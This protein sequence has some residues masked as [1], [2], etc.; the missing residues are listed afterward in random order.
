MNKD[1]IRKTIDRLPAIL[2]AIKDSR[3][4]TNSNRSDRS[5]KAPPLVDEETLAIIG[6]LDDIIEHEPTDWIRKLLESFKRKKTD[7][8]RME[9]VPVSRAKYDLIKSGLVD[10]IYECCISKGYVTYSD[11]M[12]EK[13]R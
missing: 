12:N 10:K 5:A 6:I 13:I 11:I 1:K 3:E 4:N 2:K 7:I 8:S 9:E